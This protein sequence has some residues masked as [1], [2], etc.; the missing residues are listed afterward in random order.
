MSE[1]IE[2]SDDGVITMPDVNQAAPGVEWVR[3]PLDRDVL[4]ELNTRSDFMGFL[5]TFGHLGLLC[6]TATGVI[7]GFEHKI[8][9]LLGVCLFLHGTMFHFVLNG[10]HE[11][12][13]NTVFK[14]RF[15]NEF[16]LR[17]F[18][19][20]GQHNHVWFRTS[21]KE[22]HQHTMYPPRDLEN[23]QPIKYR[24]KDFF[25]SA[26]I[27]PLG[28]YPFFKAR[29]RRAC[30]YLDDEW[31]QYIFK[32]SEEKQKQLKNVERFHFFVHAII[33]AVSIYMQWWM[34]PVLTTFAPFYLSWLL[35]LCNNTQHVGLHD[36]VPDFR[37][38]SRTIYLNPF[39]QFIYW[40]M[41]Y[42]V[43]HHM[44]AGVPCYK[45]GK[46][47]RLIKDQM[48]PTPNGLLPAWREIAEILKKQEADPD[49]QYAP[50]IPG[51]EKEQS[52]EEA[53]AETA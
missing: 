32:D 23:I 14:S 7:Y 51:L 11:L 43:E 28:L 31:T 37:L 52:S 27:N 46:L 30:G 9:W 53:V 50:P 33:I 20:I 45:L 8:W 4:K 5:Q 39:F 48:P 36:N 49:F 40:H 2:N 47:H 10:F 41:N 35:F 29:I 21:H 26:F 16:F 1:T 42:H 44:Y 15:L 38:N 3:V 12:C 18:S 25:K 34:V 19:V 13:H 22:H 6:L 17:V 24:R